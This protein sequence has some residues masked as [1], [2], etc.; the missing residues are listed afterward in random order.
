[1][2]EKNLKGFERFVHERSV[3]YG[4]IAECALST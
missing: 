1:M 4:L 3:P 2:E